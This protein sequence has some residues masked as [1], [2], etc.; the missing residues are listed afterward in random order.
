MTHPRLK[1]RQRLPSVLRVLSLLQTNGDLAQLDLDLLSRRLRA[2]VV[3]V[4]HSQ[5]L[6]ETDDVEGGAVGLLIG[7]TSR[8]YGVVEVT[9]HH[10]DVALHPSLVARQRV[11]G[12]GDLADVGS[13]VRQ[14]VLGVLACLVRLASYRQGEEVN[15]CFSSLIL[16]INIILSIPG[17][18]RD[19]SKVVQKLTFFFIL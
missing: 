15:S 2:R 1:F 18:E 11:D 14:F 5:L 6:G 19:S 7:G 10:L 4:L 17:R 13:C 16:E 8:Q 12:D 3:V 9:V